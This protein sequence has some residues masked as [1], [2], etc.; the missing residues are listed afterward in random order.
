MEGL[1]N[2]TLGEFQSI[3]RQKKQRERERE[4]ELKSRNTT[5]LN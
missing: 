5:S 4:R 2:Q 3:K 1:F